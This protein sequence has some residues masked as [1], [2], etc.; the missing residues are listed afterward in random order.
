MSQIRHGVQRVLISFETDAE[1]L[2]GCGR[3][4]FIRG[5]LLADVLLALEELSG[6]LVAAEARGVKQVGH[7]ISVDL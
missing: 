3:V 6:Y 4:E 7:F 2:V 5:H 1:S